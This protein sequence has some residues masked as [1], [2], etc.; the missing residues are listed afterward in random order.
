MERI[1]RPYAII[2]VDRTGET[3]L[4]A[5]FTPN[6]VIN[7]YYNNPGFLQWNYYLIVAKEAIGERSKE[8][9]EKCDFYTRKHV[10]EESKIDEFIADR[11]PEMKASHGT[12]IIVKGES[13]SSTMKDATPILEKNKDSKVIF[14]WYR[15]E[16]SMFS[17]N[18]MDK[19]RADMIKNSDYNTIFCTHITNEHAIAEKKFKLFL[20]KEI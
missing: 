6:D 14:S 16:S 5:D 18:E 8:E 4:S 10:I 13:W 9:I 3:L 20:N 12:M 1:E 2:Y 19:V 17:L 15:D 7:D 11:F